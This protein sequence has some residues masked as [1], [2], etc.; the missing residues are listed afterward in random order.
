MLLTRLVSNLVS[1]AYRYGVENGRI[2]ITLLSNSKNAM[3]CVKDNGIGI[4]KD[5]QEKYSADFIRPTLRIT[6]A[7][8]VSD[9]RW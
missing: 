9:C 6:A 8:R 5:E 4:A 2:N 3:L 7:E 1:N